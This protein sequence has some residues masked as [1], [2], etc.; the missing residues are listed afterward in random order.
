MPILFTGK[1]GKVVGAR[2]SSDTNTVV[3]I[4]QSSHHH[5]RVRKPPMGSVNMLEDEIASRKGMWRRQRQRET[6]VEKRVVDLQQV[7]KWFVRDIYLSPFVK[8]VLI[9]HL[10]SFV[11]GVLL[12]SLYSFS[13]LVFDLLCSRR[14]YFA[15]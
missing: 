6:D 14:D 7:N 4:V 1:A 15:F 10:L 5:L 12:F 13:R 9:C 2:I 3:P 11:F 8:A